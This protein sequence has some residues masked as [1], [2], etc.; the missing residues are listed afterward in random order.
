VIDLSEVVFI[1]RIVVGSNN[2]TDIQSEERV[3][4]QIGLLN[5]CLS[6]HPKGKLIG[7]EKS[8]AILQVG[9]HNVVL[10][11]TTYHVGFTRKPHWLEE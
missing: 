3:A 8:F 1:K 10:Q 4:E 7:A 9:E 6:D 11:W 5:R 2:P